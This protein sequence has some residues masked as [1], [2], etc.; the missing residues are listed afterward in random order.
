[1]FKVV[2]QSVISGNTFTIHYESDTKAHNGIN[3][4]V[5]KGAYV[6]YITKT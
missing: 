4:L 5:N 1:M 3:N 2:Y 6:L